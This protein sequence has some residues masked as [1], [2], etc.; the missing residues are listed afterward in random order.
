MTLARRLSYSVYRPATVVS[1]MYWPVIGLLDGDLLILKAIGSFYKLRPTSHRC[2]FISCNSRDKTY[3]L[4]AIMAEQI[5][6][7][8]KSSKQWDR[9]QSPSR[10][11]TAASVSDSA[12]EAKSP[13]PIASEPVAGSPAIDPRLVSLST[14]R[15]PETIPVDDGLN[16]R[17]SRIV[18]EAFTKA[19]PNLM[20]APAGTH[21]SSHSHRCG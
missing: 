8:K 14:W 9:V 2:H 18:T 4:S 16:D 5:K 13:L 1:T 19:L 20:A 21:W 10:K 6:S 15:N 17:I 3:I 12:A 11:V 7:S